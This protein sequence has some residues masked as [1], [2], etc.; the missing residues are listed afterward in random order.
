V[1]TTL[2]SGPLVVEI[3]S[4]VGPHAAG[5]RFTSA[6]HASLFLRRFAQEPPNLS[7]LRRLLHQRFHLEIARFADAEIIDHVARLLVTGRL[8]L[9][10]QPLEPLGTRDL[11]VPD[12]PAAP[13][14]RPVPVE[15]KTWIEI[16]LLDMDDNP[17][18][19]EPYWIELTDGSIREGSLN[20]KGRAYFGDLDAGIC[21]VRWPRLDDSATQNPASATRAPRAKVAASDRAGGEAPPDA[22]RDAAEAVASAEERA[23]GG[24]PWVTP[25]REREWIEIELLDMDD[26]PVPDERYRITLTD[27]SVREGRLDS[28]GRAYFGD[29][30]TGICEVGWP[31]LDDS[32]AEPP[33][34][35]SRAPAQGL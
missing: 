19:G 17:M 8:S 16:E 33:R 13:E 25:R 26:R 34:G 29:L 11:V 21:E 24:A 31:D 15:E 35:S 10:R 7:A 23:G 9:A 2:R 14:A 6:L 1:K 18:P 20:D 28:A 27:G 12:E 22:D 32:A 3:A 5:V 4:H 30:D